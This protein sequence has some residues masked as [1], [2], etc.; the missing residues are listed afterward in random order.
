MNVDCSCPN[1]VRDIAARFN[2]DHDAVLNVLHPQ[3]C[4]S[5]HQIELLGFVAAKFYEE[6]GAFK[7]L[8]ID[9]IVALFRDYFPGPGQL[10]ERRQ[11][12]AQMLS[13][14]K[15]ISE[16]LNRHCVS[17]IGVWMLSLLPYI[18]ICIVCNGIST[19]G[20]TVT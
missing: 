3:A 15:K 6:R 19:P 5:E 1:R 11:K 16:G 9:T 7:L 20:G 4:T 8:I 2:M 13:R 17:F 12:L 18:L 14:L 10:A